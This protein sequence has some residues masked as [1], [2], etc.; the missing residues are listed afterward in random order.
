MR[1]WRSFFFRFGGNAG[2]L[3]KLAGALNEMGDLRLLPRCVEVA[4]R[5]GYGL[6]PF[7][8]LQ[9]ESLLK[10]GDWMRASALVSAVAAAKD[11]LPENIRLWR[12]WA[13]RIVECARIHTEATQTMILD[14]L[15]EHRWPVA[16]VRQ[17]ILIL[18]T[19]DRYETAQEVA[20]L[21]LRTFPASRWLQAQAEAI[22]LELVARK[23]ALPVE[24]VV[25]AAPTERAFRS[26][27]DELVKAEKWAETSQLIQ[28]V[29]QV[30]PPPAWLDAHES[31]VRLAQIKIGRA[32]K[33]LSAMLAAAR[34]YLNGGDERARELLGLA[35]QSYAE[36]EARL[37]LGLT[38]EILQ[39]SPDFAPAKSELAKWEKELAA[40]AAK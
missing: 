32:Q 12:D 30:A 16:L 4:G 35:R 36:G 24:R 6:V 22:R 38:R 18:R 37:A 27:L 25:E 17:T 11:P 1:R 5:Q 3:L 9:A 31:A 19:V 26:K 8:M 10:H 15:R 2:T 40:G 7:Q 39:R 13:G 28:R 20:A 21:G 34:L 29:Q 14:Y 33:D 23:E